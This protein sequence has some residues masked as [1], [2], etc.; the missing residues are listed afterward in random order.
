MEGGTTSS[1]TSASPTDQRMSAAACRLFCD[2]L[3]AL[4]TLKTTN[5]AMVALATTSRR[6]V[7]SVDARR[8]GPRLKSC[9]AQRSRDVLSLR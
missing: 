3:G 7:I 6:L 1:D 4:P 5:L 8:E 2:V 9:R